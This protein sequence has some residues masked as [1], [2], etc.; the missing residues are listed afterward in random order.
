MLE[1]KMIDAL[2]VQ[3][4][5]ELKSAYIYQAMSADFADKNRPGQTA[6]MQEQAKEEVGHAMKIYNY[7]LEQGAKVEL[8]AIDAPQTSWNSEKDMFEVALKHEKYISGCIKKLVKIARELD[9]VP[10]EIFLQWFVLEQVEEESSV[11][12]ILG[13]YNQVGSTPNGLYMLDKELGKR[14]QSH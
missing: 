6:W 14:V 4:N 7:L 10:T 1:K 3:V 11:E 13:K 9:D 8:K 12:E 2:N 5:E